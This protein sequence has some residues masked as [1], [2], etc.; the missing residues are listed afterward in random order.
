ML[1]ESDSQQRA[2]NA[3]ESLREGVENLHIDLGEKK[4]SI[5]I[6]IGISVWKPGDDINHLL[7]FADSALYTA[8]N[9][10]RNRVDFG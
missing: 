9:S 7:K 2:L 3:A 10:G 6:S 4:I 5:T 8:K 1:F